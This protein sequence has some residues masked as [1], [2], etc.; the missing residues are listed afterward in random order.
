MRL[1]LLAGACAL[2]APATAQNDI[3]WLTLDMDQ[4]RMV[5][6]PHLGVNDVQEKD[7][8]WAD[9]DKDGWTDLVVVRKEPFTT[10][11]RFPNVLFM[12]EGGTLVDRTTEY[13]SASDVNGDSG[14]L[15]PT[16]DRDVV[17][18][19]VDGDTWLDVVTAPTISPGHPKHISHPR[20]YMNLGNDGNGDW[21]GLFFEDARTPDHGTFPTYC[22]VGAGDVTGNGKPDLYFA[23]YD[24]GAE[25]DLNDRLL[26]NDGTGVFT[27]ETAARL[28]SNMTASFFGSAA[29][30]VDLNGD[31][32]QDV[33]DGESGVVNLIYNDPDNEG[34]FDILHNPYFGAP[35]HVTP[36]DLN[37]DGKP[38]LL[39][40]DD[41]QDRYM[42]NEGNDGLGRVIWSSPHT[43]NTDDGF[44]SNNL[45]VDMN[46][47]GWAE[48]LYCDVDVDIPGC[49]RRFHLFHNRGGAVGGF[50]DLHEESG[51]GSVGA[52]G[53]SAP[54]IT[55]AHDVAAFDI[56]NDG[57]KD[58]VLGRCSGTQVY[59]N[60]LNEPVGT[61]FCD[62]SVPN[63]TGAPGMI[64]ASGSDVVADNDVTLTALNLPPNKA[65][66]FLASMTQGFIQNPGGSQGN[67]CL[68][69]AGRYAPQI[70]SSGPEGII[71]LQIDLDSVP[72]PGGAVA[73]V[74]GETWSFTLWHRDKNPGQTSNFTDGVA[75]PFQ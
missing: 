68:Q 39:I 43:Y 52:T 25:F 4:A 23:H 50:V 62:P 22:G 70:M 74:P 55:G 12:N 60:G 41:A 72:Q 35:Y 38:D 73:V 44:A 63:S 28:T 71:S 24:S 7:Y 54:T 40:S 51:G 31:G 20:V 67:L 9:L 8:A 75:I 46:G 2:A 37:R 33:V 57:D 36:G 58:M 47:D 34:F 5:S 10:A 1:A 48:A 61:R 64:S 56:D 15:T 13:A 59:M 66:Y 49:S 11:G 53:L 42:L 18:A 30:M 29:T 14:F 6:A 16:N 27:D 45:A 26:V 69:G 65:G 17:I 3:S 19:D 32:V 21:L